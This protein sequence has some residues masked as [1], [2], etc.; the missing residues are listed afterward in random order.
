MPTLPT[1]IGLEY[2]TRISPLNTFIVYTGPTHMVSTITT[3][4]DN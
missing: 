1:M 2:M 3:G 4:I